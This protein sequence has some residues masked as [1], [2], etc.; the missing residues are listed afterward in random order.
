MT[1]R[2][3]VVIACFNQ[4]RELEL[5][6]T[7][8]LQQDFPHFAYEL[9]VIDDHSTDYSA[10][11]CVGKLRKTYPNSTLL[12]VRQYR[13]DGGSYGASACVKNIGIRLARGDYVFFN[14]SEITQAG[15]TLTYILKT[16]DAASEPLC[17]R[18]RVM[19]L[20]FE[21]LEGQSQTQLETIY[22]GVPAERERVATADHAGL[23]CVS[24]R[25]LIEVGG[26][27]ER[28]DY[29]GKEDLDLAARLKRAGA[30]YVYD[31]QLKSFH[32]S[33]PPNH[34]KQ[35]DYQR[36]CTLLEEN[37]S[38]ELIEANRGRLWGAL[39]PAPSETLRGTV[40][41]EADSNI[42][43]LAA[44]LESVVYSPRAEEYEVLVTCLDI[45]RSAVESLV[46]SHYR[47]VPVISLAPDS[48][49]QQEARVRRQVRTEKL[50]F[51]PAGGSF[52]PP[53]ISL[54]VGPSK[55]SSVTG[56]PTL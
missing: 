25:L 38:R 56:G 49:D 47:P 13:P 26:N 44:R 27:D 30:S 31:T 3:S 54:S 51:L 41:V 19:D 36:M 40:V 48:F 34:C 1:P 53:D 22:D 24:R 42:A 6:L 28:F 10:R 5:T 52:T 29:W 37:N 20:P 7:S 33:H 46:D 45:D 55:C 12:Y 15:E 8:F 43:D 50:F 23:A 21:Q 9:I 39:S 11:D 16:M 35:G 2:I 18:G 4:T 32:I 14:N 17:L